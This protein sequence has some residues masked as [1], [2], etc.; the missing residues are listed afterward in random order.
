M[1]LGPSLIGAIVGAAIGVG[2]QVAF[3][4]WL[5]REAIWF[6]I[7]I[8]VLTGFG[9]R[10]LAGAAIQRANY[11]RAGL[12]ALV[13][14]GAIVGGSYA[15][16]EYTRQRSVAAYESAPKY[17]PRPAQPA[18][19]EGA[20]DEGDDQADE[21]DEPADGGDAADGDAESEGDE[22]TTTDAENGAAE[23][24][25]A[26]DDA[27]DSGDDADAPADTDDSA[28]VDEDEPADAD[29]PADPVAVA[30]AG[31][32]PL[33]VEVPEAVAGEIPLSPWQFA[34]FGLGAFLA[35]E[36]ARGGGQENQPATTDET[37]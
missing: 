6:A 3:E 33:R 7:V 27:A 20:D 37:A 12:S 31:S 30:P 24:S 36:L 35:Y 14:L 2:A 19:D 16:S 28:T 29:E 8:G 5:G 11:L 21:G 34:F 13:A 22:D 18:D 17:E 32:D 10:T 9:A 4:S 15:A 1:K 25:D 26:E 23:G